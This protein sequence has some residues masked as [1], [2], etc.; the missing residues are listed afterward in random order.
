MLFLDRPVAR[1]DIPGIE[2]GFEGEDEAVWKQF[3]IPA[4]RMVSSSLKLNLSGKAKGVVVGEVDDFE[5][6]GWST[7]PPADGVA[8]A[9]ALGAPTGETT[10][11][12]LKG[13]TVVFSASGFMPMY[14]LGEVSDLLEVEYDFD[15]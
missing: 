7:V 14:R 4:F 12:I 13:G 2:G 9:T 6:P 5:F 8:A 3:E 11:M 1:T 10:L 15:D